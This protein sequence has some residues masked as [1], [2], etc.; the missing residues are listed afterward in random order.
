MKILPD[1]SVYDTC[2]FKDGNLYIKRKE[3]TGFS[4][5][6]NKPSEYSWFYIVALKGQAG[7]TIT[8]SANISPHE[9]PS[10]T[11]QNSLAFYS[12]DQY[13]WH[14]LKQSV[15][16]DAH[17]L[18]QRYKFTLPTDQIIYLSNT[19]FF[20]YQSLQRTTQTIAANHPDKC[21]TH[22]IGTSLNGNN[23]ELLSF[24]KTINPLGRILVTTGCHPAEPDVIGS[25]AI[26]DYLTSPAAATLR[27]HYIIDVMPIQN[28]DGFQQKSCLTANGINLYWNF[29]KDDQT[30]CPEAYY[31]WRYITKRPPMLY[32]DFHAYV[33]QYHRKP[34]PYLK[35]LTAYQGKRPKEIV[36][37]MD[38]LLKKNAH[39]NYHVGQITRWPHA[40]SYHITKQFNTIAYTKYHFNLYEGIAASQERAK[41]IFTGL[42][43]ILLQNKVDATQILIPPPP[44]QSHA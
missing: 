36:T 11:R 37:K 7:Q 23:L 15:W 31:L 30:N 28:P 35:P 19:I 44:R 34:M 32:L 14:Q 29:R 6:T 25:L 4:V 5:G 21:T 26:L 3:F 17:G 9:Q 1:Q 18:K 33:H 38:L 39:H 24:N 42:T 16:T 27:E 13:Q 41:T 8:V 40:L 43:D 10:L 12:T 2:D 20:D 22:T